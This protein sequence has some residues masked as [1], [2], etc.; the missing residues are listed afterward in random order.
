ME[1]NKKPTYQDLEKQ[2]DELKS[3]KQLIN[4][5]DNFNKLLK[6]SEDMI[7]IHEPNGKYIYYKGPEYYNITPEDIVGKMPNDLFSKDVCNILMDTF[8]KVKKKGESQTVEVLLDWMG[9]KRWF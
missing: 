6:A 9:E 3:K 1:L 2:I 4:D 5:E 8:K 7:T